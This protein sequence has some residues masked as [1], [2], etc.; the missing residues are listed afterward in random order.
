MNKKELDIDKIDSDFRKTSAMF[1]ELSSV[2]HGHDLICR[3]YSRLKRMIQKKEICKFVAK[4]EIGDLKF[5]IEKTGNLKPL[6]CFIKK[7]NELQNSLEN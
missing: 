4:E 2:S 7:L 6:G 5:M 3:I 1:N